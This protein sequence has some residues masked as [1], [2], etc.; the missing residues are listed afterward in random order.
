MKTSTPVTSADQHDHIYKSSPRADS[1]VDTASTM[2]EDDAMDIDVG[3]QPTDLPI[4]ASSGISADNSDADAIISCICG[5][6]KGYDD[7]D[8]I[9]CDRCGTWQHTLCYFY[10]TPM[11]AED[12]TYL[13]A[14]CAPRSGLQHP[15]AAARMRKKLHRLAL[16]SDRISELRCEDSQRSSEIDALELEKQEIERDFEILGP[17]LE[18]QGFCSDG[19]EVLD[20][21]YTDLQNIR[22]QL[23]QL[24]RT[25]AQIQSQLLALEGDLDR[26]KRNERTLK[27]EARDNWT[28]HD[29]ENRLWR[30]LRAFMVL[31]GEEELLRAAAAAEEGTRKPRKKSRR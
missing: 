6:G 22:K 23:D 10:L 28:E 7:D 15:L 25:R 5:F 11:P 21:W 3:A 13:C 24:R 26:V 17:V 9:M 2:N 8:A 16:F 29:I 1:F 14:T 4:A 31:P 20:Q 18:A 27:E 12:A 19:W 30:T